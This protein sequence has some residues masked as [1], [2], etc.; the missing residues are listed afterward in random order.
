M[1]GTRCLMREYILG[2]WR[3]CYQH[4][5]WISDGKTINDSV[6]GWTYTENKIVNGKVY[7]RRGSQMTKGGLPVLVKVGQKHVKAPRMAKESPVVEEDS[8]L[9]GGINA[10]HLALRRLVGQY[11]CCSL[12]KINNNK[13]LAI[14]T[15][16]SVKHFRGG[17]SVVI[18][19]GEGGVSS[20]LHQLMVTSM[21]W[22]PSK[23]S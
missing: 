10:L 15:D 7:Y 20:V 19:N 17:A 1:N 4:W 14:A 21:T 16:D 18:N 9:E 12:P 2:K 23:R 6:E 13:R 11:K 5:R 3:C 8:L 22:I